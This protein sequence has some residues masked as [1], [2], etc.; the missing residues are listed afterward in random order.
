MHLR[1]LRQRVSSCKVASSSVLLAALLSRVKSW[2][3]TKGCLMTKDHITLSM[4]DAERAAYALSVALAD[5]ETWGEFGGVL[6][7]DINASR[8]LQKRL[9]HFAQATLKKASR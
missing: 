8:E 4:Q 9:D 6:D 3:N 2:A 5:A 7:N 1:D